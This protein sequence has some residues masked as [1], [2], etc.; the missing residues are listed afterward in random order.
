MP[1]MFTL[2]NVIL[3]A[4]PITITVRMGLDMQVRYWITDKL[5]LW[6]LA[7]IGLF[8]LTHIVHTLSRS[9][10]R[11]WI[12]LCLAG[13]CFH[14]LLLGDFVLLMVTQT[15]NTLQS[16]D[17]RTDV[18]KRYLQV[19]WENARAFYKVCM[20]ETVASTLSI[21][22]VAYSL[23]RIQDCE[24]YEA[25]VAA[26]PAWPYMGALEDE[27][28]CGGWCFQSEPLWTFK[29][30]KDSCAAVVADVLNNKVKPS[31]QQVVGYTFIVLGVVT[32]G[33]IQ[34]GPILKSHNIDWNTTEPKGDYSRFKKR[35][36]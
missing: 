15:A 23:Y 5:H 21:K 8:I 16:K 17:C 13:A 28:Q 4:A 34:V 29:T 25:G 3:F 11:F 26:N 1:W 14:Q 18:D 30:T 33:L 9:P 12:C 7:L 35:E 22:E 19:Q 6:A 24:G 2:L 32:F 10:S 36:L 31:M 20:A 27:Y